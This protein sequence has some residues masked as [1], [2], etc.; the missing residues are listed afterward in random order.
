MPELPEFTFTVTVTTD[1]VEHAAEAI[2]NRVCYDEDLGFDYS[3]SWPEL[4]AA[5]EFDGEATE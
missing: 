1:T 2:S 4:V 3:L 5:P